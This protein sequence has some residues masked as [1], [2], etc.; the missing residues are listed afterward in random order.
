MPIYSVNLIKLN[1]ILLYLLNLF[2]DL[3]YFMPKKK[4]IKE[5]L[6]I[7]RAYKD[8]NHLIN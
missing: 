2:R 6:V 5:S 1:I 7:F 4:Q 3:I 8:I